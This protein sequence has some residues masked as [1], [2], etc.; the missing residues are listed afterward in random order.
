MALL[1]EKLE[2]TQAAYFVSLFEGAASEWGLEYFESRLKVGEQHNRIDLPIK[3]HLGSY[4]ELPS[5]KHSSAQ[6]DSR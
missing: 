1:R 4:S 2:H 3:W 6:S 5:G